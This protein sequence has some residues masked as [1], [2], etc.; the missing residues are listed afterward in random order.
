MKAICNQYERYPNWAVGPISRRNAF[1]IYTTTEEETPLSD[2][3]FN[4]VP[5]IEKKIKCVSNKIK[6][7]SLYDYFNKNL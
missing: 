5:S 7:R 1:G 4:L 3:F 6:A 2:N